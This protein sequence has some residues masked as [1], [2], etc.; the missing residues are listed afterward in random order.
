MNILTDVINTTIM[1]LEFASAAVIAWFVA[2][3]VTALF[4]K[5]VR[6]FL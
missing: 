6:T 5:T 4:V 1:I 3:A 2:A